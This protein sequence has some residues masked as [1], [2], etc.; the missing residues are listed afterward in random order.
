MACRVDVGSSACQSKDSA[1][2]PGIFLSTHN[3][4]R[5]AKRANDV[6]MAFYEHAQRARLPILKHMPKMYT[7]CT[8]KGGAYIEFENMKRGMQ[9][10]VELDIKLGKFS[11]DWNDLVAQGLS[12]FRVAF[13]TVY[14]TVANVVSGRIT[15]HF[16]PARFKWAHVRDPHAAF[17]DFFQGGQRAAR[18]RIVPRLRAI[19]EALRQ[20][21]HLRTVGMSVLLV[22][23]RSNPDKVNV[24]LIDFAH[25]MPVDRAHP[26]QGYAVSG[27]ENVA[28]C[29]EAI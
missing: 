14:R 13:K 12:Y 11:A 8:H 25:T 27:I 2:H 19:A 22:Y 21:P 3:G 29:I 10:P 20:T 24:K 5:C 9:S 6:E 1:G 26:S 4:A 17:R 7:K 23:D 18:A 15:R 16:A 28:R